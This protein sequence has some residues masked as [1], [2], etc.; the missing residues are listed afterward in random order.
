MITVMMDT[1]PVFVQNDDGLFCLKSAQAILEWFQ[2]LA[3]DSHYQ[4]DAD[5]FIFISDN[6]EIME[7]PYLG[8]GYDIPFPWTVV[9]N[10]PHCL[11]P[12]PC[13]CKGDVVVRLEM[14]VRGNPELPPITDDEIAFITLT[15]EMAQNA[16]PRRV[17]LNRKD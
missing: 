2:R 15:M 17:H 11:V 8:T 5:A 9:N 16:L 7:C 4:S 12:N 10:C 14:V 1:S 6:G 13:D 3:P